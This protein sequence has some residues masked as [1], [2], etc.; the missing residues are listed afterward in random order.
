MSVIDL[1]VQG[2]TA[3]LHKLLVG[4]SSVAM[5]TAAKAILDTISAA[6]K[7]RERLQP[8]HVSFTPDLVTPL[9]LA[10]RQ[11]LLNE[12]ALGV[13]REDAPV[14]VVGTEPAYEPG[15]AADLPNVCLESYCCHVVWLCGGVP[16]VVS[17][18]SGG[19]VKMR[20][21]RA[22]HIHPS[23]HYAEGG[24]HTWARLSSIV[25]AGD[26]P[27][28][29]L[30]DRCHQ[31]DL[32]A[33]PSQHN[34][35][36]LPPTEARIRFLEQVFSTLR[37]TARVLLFHGRATDPRLAEARDRLT[38]A[39]A[40]MEPRSWQNL[41]EPNRPLRYADVTDR[42]VIV[43]RALAN[44]GVT[45]EFLERLR[46]LVHFKAVTL[47]EAPTVAPRKSPASDRVRFEPPFRLQLLDEATAYFADTLNLRLWPN[48]GDAKESNR[49][50]TFARRVRVGVVATGDLIRVQLHAEDPDRIA[51]FDAIMDDLRG[52]RLRPPVPG[53]DMSIR[54]GPRKSQRRYLETAWPMLDDPDGHGERI[55]A[56][57]SWLPLIRDRFQP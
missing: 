15:Q 2:Y 18:L 40:G 39:F 27:G 23:D 12:H 44:S 14:V 55:A 34:S 13:G 38:K 53:L 42:R 56:F 22:F 48:G 33:L 17:K 54:P 11:L 41:S 29:E 57:V 5:Q 10:E 32:S 28:A 47:P 36:G 31:I 45:P 35:R 50:G 4:Q 52:G 46:N 6:Q 19:K 9:S 7:H 1:A 51:T 20:A 8:Q 24:G 37:S 25:E 21:G 30:G 26:Q 16:A 43:T 3:R 49:M